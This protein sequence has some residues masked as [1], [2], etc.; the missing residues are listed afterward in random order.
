M[1]TELQVSE[2][3]LAIPFVINAK[4]HDS[5]FCADFGG[6]VHQVSVVNEF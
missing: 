2:N 6:S 3:R 4:L 1:E 5:L